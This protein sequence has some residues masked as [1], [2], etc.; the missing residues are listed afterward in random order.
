MG[1]RTEGG[2]VYEFGVFVRRSDVVHMVQSIVLQL[3]KVGE[4]V[5][6]LANDRPNF[7]SAKM[8]VSNLARR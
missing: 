3:H 2:V 6:D 1:K 7:R 4:E 8:I 5:R